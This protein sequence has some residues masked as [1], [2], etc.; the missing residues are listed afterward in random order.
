MRRQYPPPKR[1]SVASPVFPLMRICEGLLANNLKSFRLSQI[2]RIGL[3]RL[4]GWMYNRQSPSY[5]YHKSF[6]GTVRGFAL[7]REPAESL[8]RSRVKKSAKPGPEHHAHGIFRWTSEPPPWSE[9][10]HGKHLSC[11]AEKYSNP[12]SIESF[13]TQY[14]F[15]IANP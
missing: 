10:A 6:P 12:A 2:G 13:E 5:K 11:R 14:F 4:A 3:K 1:G 8:V 9:S 7:T 15:I